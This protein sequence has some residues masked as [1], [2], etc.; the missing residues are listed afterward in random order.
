MGKDSEDT[1]GDARRDESRARAD[2]QRRTEPEQAEQAEQ[3]EQVE[4]A[5]QANQGPAERDAT[6]E[7]RG[8]SPPQKRITE[9]Y[10]NLIEKNN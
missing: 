9:K 4:Q 2:E 5:E 3:A 8:K 6:E 10:S 1:T 7:R